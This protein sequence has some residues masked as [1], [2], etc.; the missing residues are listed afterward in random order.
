R[1]E[2]TPAGLAWIER[3]LHD[4]HEHKSTSVEIFSLLSR[5]RAEL[6]LDLQ[7]KVLPDLDE[8]EKLIQQTQ[9]KDALLHVD[10]TFLRAQLSFAKGQAADA[11]V[12]T[13]KLLPMLGYPAQRTSARLAGVLTLRSR[14]Q[15]LLDRKEE[16][17]QTARA[18]LI[19]AEDHA[20]DSAR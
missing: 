16:A 14:A 10:T 12:A 13:D 5:A 8:V 3:A 4:A 1:I 18:A 19:V 2:E 17:L 7:D 20:L 9:T 11:L 15:L 6:I